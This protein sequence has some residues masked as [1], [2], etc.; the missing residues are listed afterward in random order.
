M[1]QLLQ[2]A[3]TLFVLLAAACALAAEPEGKLP[4]G[5]VK[6]G[7][8]VLE[9][10]ADADATVSGFYIRMTECLPPRDEPI[11][12]A[13]YVNGKR[14]E[15]T[16]AVP[17]F[18]TPLRDFSLPYPFDP[19]VFPPCDVG[20]EFRTPVAPTAIKKGDAVRIAVD[21]CGAKIET[22]IAAG[23]QLQGPKPLA[24]MR[25][26]FRECR[27]N[28]PV[29]TIPW[30]EPEIVAVGSQAKFDP[31][32]APQNNSSVIAD[33]DGTLY[34]FCAYYSVDE[35]YGGG[36]TGSYSRIIGYKKAPG[37]DKWED[38]GIVV[39]LLEGQTYSGDPYV[40]RDLDGRPCIVFCFCD[41][42]NGFTDWQFGGNAVVRSKT[43]SFSGPWEEPK[44]LWSHYPQ[45]PDDKKTAGRA[46]C[47][48]IFPRKETQDY[49]VLW[50]HGSL[51][52]DI[53]GVVMK[54]FDTPLTYEQVCS[55]PLFVNN[56]EE[57]GGGFVYGNKAY[58]STWQ[59]PWRND[60]NGQ[61]RLYEIDLTE[62]VTPESWRAVTGSIGSND[63]SNPK[64]D[65]GTTADAWAISVAGGRLWATSCE[66]SST[67]NKNYLYA[68]SA[69]IEA[70]EEYV[71]GIKKEDVVFKYGAVRPDFYREVFPTV[72]YALGER[73]SLEYD[74][75]SWGEE[76]YALL[77]I[78]PSSAPNV[79][80]SVYFELN[81]DGARIASFKNNDTRSEGYINVL[82]S[83]DGPKWEPGKKY[84]I[85][86]VRDGAH[87][88]AYV[89]GKKA[90][91]TTVEDEEIL[92]NLNDNP[93]FK[94]YGWRAGRYEI[95]NA[96]LTDGAE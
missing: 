17:K 30:S 41:G 22:G 23:V 69:P 86:V 79:F 10:T 18:G 16:A 46:N 7:A 26:P 47:V 88:E 20:L 24:Q 51:D 84:R 95:S 28:G 91:E 6:P 38:I 12:A 66:Y 44:F 63:G 83:A 48:R 75:T 4:A 62:P 42:T 52:M 45:Y 57:G 94:F 21:S 33:E 61:Q 74:F 11:A 5:K 39:D 65:G 49:L 56:Q 54:N 32:C 58:Y 67:E 36:R 80:R 71:K 90:V 93:R 14:I 29:C 60:P 25:A 27:T 43:A 70:F 37:A 35:Q 34:I 92:R 19:Q 96:V 50:N 3:T 8:A 55:A 53:R 2:R 72:E 85:K 13:L 87:I 64:R 78:G 15:G 76:S 77:W 73:C 1:K 9:W 81:R 89:D 59:I 40:F 68:R 82:A 31:R